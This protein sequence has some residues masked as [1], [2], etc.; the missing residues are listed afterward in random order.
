[1]GKLPHGE[2]SCLSIRDYAA[3]I[4][5]GKTTLAERRRS[6][7]VPLH[8][9]ADVE[10][11]VRSLCKLSGGTTA[12]GAPSTTSA[13]LRQPCRAPKSQTG[14]PQRISTISIRACLPDSEPLARALDLRPTWPCRVLAIIGAYFVADVGS[15]LFHVIL[16]HHTVPRALAHG[17]GVRVTTSNREALPRNRF[18]L[19]WPRSPMRRWPSWPSPPASKDGFH[20]PSRSPHRN[21]SSWLF[22]QLFHR[23]HLPRV[24]RGIAT[25]Q[26]ARL[27]IRPED[28]AAHHR[29]PYLRRFGVINGWSNPHSIT[30]TSPSA[31]RAG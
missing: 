19:I 20:Q 9:R 12:N 8:I 24:P 27:I 15:Y 22:G 17:R 16:D 26:R 10:A 30:T 21:S 4:L 18:P 5:F 7:R 23:G 1:M 11:A 3:K 25:L 2:K 29:A 28:H 6:Y 13:T 14:A 31:S